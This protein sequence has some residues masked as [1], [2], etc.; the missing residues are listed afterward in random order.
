MIRRFIMISMVAILLLLLLP[1]PLAHA[2]IVWGNQL[3]HEARDEA[4]RLERNAFIVNSES[5]YITSRYDPRISEEEEA[6]LD[7][8]DRSVSLRKRENGQTIIL[9]HVLYIDG[10][11]WGIEDNRGHRGPSGWYP[12]SQL[13]VRYSRSDFNET[14]ESEFYEF[15]GEINMRQIRRATDRIVTWSW[16]GSDFPKTIQNFNDDFELTNITVHFAY[17]DEQGREWGYVEIEAKVTLL[18]WGHGDIIYGH[19]SR[20]DAWIC[21]DDP[22]NMT[23]IPSFYPAPPPQ[24]WSPYEPVV[25]QPLSWAADV[26]IEPVDGGQGFANRPPIWLIGLIIIV[27]ISFGIFIVFMFKGGKKRRG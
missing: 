24:E 21:L 5:G 13:L 4:V 9:T 6:E 12:M 17:R 3:L 18:P 26:P 2:D 16:P 8:R 15:T 22:A 20:W 1:M 14:H 10:E 19:V 23:D 7:G 11:Y 25:W 27:P